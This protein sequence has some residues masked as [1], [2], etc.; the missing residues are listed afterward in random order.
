MMT[1]NQ[2]LENKIVAIIR[3]AQPDDVIKI[4][5]ALYEGGVKALEVTLNSPDALM[6]IETLSKKM[7]KELLIGAGTVLNALSAQSALSA[8]ARFI[9]SPNLDRETIQVTKESGAVS[10]PGAFTATEIVS[11][12]QY[13]GD[14]IKVF[15]ASDASYI[16]AIRGPLPHIPLMPTGGV[17]LE[18]IQAF[19]KAGA[20]A[21]GIGSALVNT[22]EEVTTEYLQQLTAKAKRFVQAVF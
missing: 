21:F 10:I 20:V 17:N 15:P 18:N 11:A 14:I 5:E 12:Y 7:E 16:K 4:A 22:R 13:G 9:I 6:V 19:Q 1:L 2:I 8:G 3:G